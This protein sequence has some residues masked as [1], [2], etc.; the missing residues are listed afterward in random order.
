MTVAQRS[1]AA[2]VIA[3]KGQAITLTRMAAGAYNP[4]TGTSPVTETEQAG[5]GVILPL[6]TFRK[7][8]GANI[9]EGDQQL[10]LSALKADGS[11]LT[12]PHVNDVVTDANG[13]DW[14]I[15]A[16]EPLSPAGLDIL[17][18]CVVRRQV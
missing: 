5:K 6:S 16:I 2:D 15:I 17:Y 13:A 3:R 7:A 12:I 1:R 10:L 11:V 9:V 4:A 18:D 8:N 14:T